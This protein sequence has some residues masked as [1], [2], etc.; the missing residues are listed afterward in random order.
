MAVVALAVAFLVRRSQ[1]E[2][3]DSPAGTSLSNTITEPY[4][5]LGG[6]VVDLAIYQNQVRVVNSWATWAPLSKT[7][8]PALNTLAAEYDPKEV[9]F[10][11]INRKEHQDYA[12][13]YLESLPELSNL[14]IVFDPS[15]NFFIKVTGYA[16]P[17]TIVFDQSGNIAEHYRGAVNLE[18]LKQRL[19]ELIA[20]D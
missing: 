16:M 10:L 17:E 7:E 18:T 19:D 11:A 2:D 5:D 9:I 8:L 6:E 1:S 15:D 13:A 20:S 4:T 14:K 3:K 12:G